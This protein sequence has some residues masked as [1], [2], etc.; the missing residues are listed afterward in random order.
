VIDGLVIVLFLFL[1]VRIFLRRRT[2]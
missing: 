1:M 2:R